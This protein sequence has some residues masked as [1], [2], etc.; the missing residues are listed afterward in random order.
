MLFEADPVQQ[1][2]PRPVKKACSAE[3]DSHLQQ[4]LEACNSE[5][6]NHLPKKRFSGRWRTRMSDCSLACMCYTS[7][8]FS[9]PDPQRHR[10]A[11]GHR[12][13]TVPRASKASSWHRTP[14]GG[15]RSLL[16]CAVQG[17]ALGP[18][19]LFLL[20]Q[21]GEGIRTWAARPAWSLVSS[22]SPGSGP[23]QGLQASNGSSGKSIPNRRPEAS[24]GRRKQLERLLLREPVL[25][26]AV[27]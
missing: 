15:L 26:P 8:N 4:L 23:T 24:A 21:P 3:R 18:P 17:H 5:A 9:A 20:S 13:V 2:T 14:G 11:S 12:S 27:F 6:P 16:A 22:S 7:R 10:R 25:D 1:S 19:Q